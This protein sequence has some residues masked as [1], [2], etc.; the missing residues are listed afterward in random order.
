MAVK[1]FVFREN[2]VDS[3]VAGMKTIFFVIFDPTWANILARK[4]VNKEF[5]K[6]NFSF[7]LLRK[8][9]VKVLLIL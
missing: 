8:T 4:R 1:K 5:L 2:S 7:Q 9:E 3:M 6:Q